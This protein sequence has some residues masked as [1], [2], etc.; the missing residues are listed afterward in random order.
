MSFLATASRPDAATIKNDGF[1]PDVEPNAARAVLRLADGTVTADRLRHALTIAII[2]VGRDLKEWTDARRAEGF[3]SLDAVPSP[4][5]IDGKS[6]ALHCYL[7]AVYS[8]AKATVIERARD[9]DVTA[10]G[11]RKQEPLE[12]S[13][14][15]L[16]RDALWA[17]SRIKERPRMTV[18]LI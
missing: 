18:E 13:P 17:I 6:L 9:Y 10:A 3:A 5:S 14:A 2:E 4:A 7:E 16:R 1:W 12:D 11:Q 15:D 8:Y